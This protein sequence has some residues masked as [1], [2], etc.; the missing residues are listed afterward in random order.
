MYIAMHT[1]VYT[2]SHIYISSRYSACFT[3]CTGHFSFDSTKLRKSFQVQRPF[4][5]LN[6]QCCNTML[7]IQMTAKK[8]KKLQAIFL[9][10]KEVITVEN[11]I[12][13]LV[14]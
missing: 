5:F 7:P 2:Q 11:L 9:F 1:C 12:R 3:H 14:K 4:L 8:Y 10:V 6:T 13:Y